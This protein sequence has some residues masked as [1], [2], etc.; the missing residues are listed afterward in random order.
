M[1]IEILYPYS[2]NLF[3]DR[4]NV[5][6]L[7]Q[8]LKEATFI[9]T[10]LN[11]EP[12]F[13]KNEVDFVYMGPM[14]EN[15]QIKVVER[16][17]PFKERL[18]SL[19]ENDVFFLLTGNALEIFAK[20]VKDVDGSGFEGL[21]LL[22]VTCKRDMFKRKNSLFKGKFEDIFIVGFQSQFTTAFSKEEGLFEKVYG[23]GL[24]E[25]ARYEGI[26]KNNLFGT[27][28]TGPLLVLNPY[29]TKKLFNLMGLNEK[30]LYLEE[31]VI[32]AYQ[33][34]VEDFDRAAKIQKLV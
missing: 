19:I 7:K 11:D 17:K 16:L 5:V 6:Y 12:Y 15:T 32:K 28:L 27:Y 25:K 21:G 33:M 10:N 26:R 1:V 4:G 29:F 18:R 2:C 22:D 9:E 31:E 14:S 8:N 24:N 30:P 34:R 23:L 20:E 13:V 3:G